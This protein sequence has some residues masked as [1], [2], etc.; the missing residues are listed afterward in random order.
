MSLMKSPAGSNPLAAALERSELFE[1]WRDPHSG[2]VS[3]LLTHRVAPI[4]QTFYFVNSG[5]SNDG[6]YLW[7]Y[8][9]FPPGGDAYY[10][11][12]LAVIDFVEQSVRQF[13]ET[14]FM[15]ASPFV[16]GA[17]GEAYWTTGLE[18][19]KRGP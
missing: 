14:Q 17:T 2:V 9:A 4:Q 1:R 12:Q 6:R 18:I 19:W 11:R 7:F 16:D 10:G 8:C 3:F 15:D 5:F 13:P